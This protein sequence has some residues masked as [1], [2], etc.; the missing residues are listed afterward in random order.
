MSARRVTAPLAVVIENANRML[1]AEGSTVVGR[2][3]TAHLL[4]S[5]L[6]DV[7]AYRGFGYLRSEFSADGTLREDYDDSRRHYY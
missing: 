3:A 7:G 6:M 5:I 2:E 4:E 1:A